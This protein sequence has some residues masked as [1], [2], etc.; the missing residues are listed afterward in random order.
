MTKDEVE[1]I[2]K[3]LRAA[4]VWRSVVTETGHPKVYELAMAINAYRRTMEPHGWPVPTLEQLLAPAEPTPQWWEGIRRGLYPA[5]VRLAPNVV[6]WRVEDIRA[7]IARLEAQPIP[8]GNQGVKA[9]KV[10]HQK[11]AKNRTG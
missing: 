8:S 4:L 10:H 5:P 7:L 3:V 6:A 9:I 1:A 2:D 11:R